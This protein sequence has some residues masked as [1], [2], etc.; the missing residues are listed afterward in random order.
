MKRNILRVVKLVALLLPAVMLVLMIPYNNQLET[1]RI[2]GFYKEGED[3]LD[4]VVLGS[5]EVFA[6][7]A[8]GL[9]YDEY[10]FTSYN[11]AISQNFIDL[12][13]P[14][15]EE[16]LRTQSPEIVVVD[17]NAAMYVSRNNRYGSIFRTYI[18]GVPLSW[19]KIRTILEFP[20]R[21][22]PLSY[23][24]PFIM[25]HGSMSL[26]ELYVMWSNVKSLEKNGGALLKG[27][28]SCLLDEY[29]GEAM[30]ISGDHSKM[31]MPEEN[32][33]KLREFLEYCQSVQ[34]TKILF[35][36]FPHRI[37]VEDAYDR[38]RQS[39]AAA[40]IIRS[41]GF[42]YI[43]M[44][45]LGEEIGLDYRQ[46]YYDDDHMNIYGQK[47]F[48]RYLSRLLTEEYGISSRKQS[49]LNRERW[50]QT[51]KYTKL[52]CAYY[53][54]LNE[55]GPKDTMLVEQAWLISELNWMERKL[56]KDGLPLTFD[57]VYA[58]Q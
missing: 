19:N 10:G 11:Y 20:Y 43:N 39:N 14:Q 24:F 54:K 34:G 9:A 16:I 27:A 55:D 57:S 38:L 28:S 29:R 45:Y 52:Y 2:Q 17:I 35:T 46:D 41:Y 5:S 47:K 36:S 25:Y 4:V 42:D 58:A 1:P 32:E 15:M 21:E 6:A 50:E 8:P 22:Q 23:Y 33:R 40:D 13:Q 37:V 49:P 30:D 44:E 56:Q 18:E 3:T 26:R 12:F 48:T 31:D 51:V 53:E 7:F